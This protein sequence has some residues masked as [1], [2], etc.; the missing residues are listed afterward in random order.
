[1]RNAE[2][3]MLKEKYGIREMM[4]RGD[5]EKKMRRWGDRGD[6]G[7]ARINCSHQYLS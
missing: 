5:R 7:T 6:A 4:E 1:M 2:C 3:G